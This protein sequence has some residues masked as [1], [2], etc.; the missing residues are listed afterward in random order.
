MSDEIISQYDYL[1]IQKM[2]EDQLVKLADEI[3]KKI[4][5]AVSSNG[6]HLSSNLGV[7]ELTIA[8]LKSFELESDDLLFDVGHQ[9]YA[10]KLLT[11]RNLALLRKK[12]GIS[13]FQD[14]DESHFEEMALRATNNNTQTVGHYIPLNK[15]RFIEILKL[16]L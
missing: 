3:R 4:L 1:D 14:I 9:T 5:V 16:S 10:F 7:I 2:D 6:G 15:E 11:K 12:D 13:G 8:L